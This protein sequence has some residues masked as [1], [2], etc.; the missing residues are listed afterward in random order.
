MKSSSLLS[1][2][3]LLAGFGVLLALLICVSLLGFTRTEHANRRLQ[4]AVHEQEVKTSLA[5]SIF[6]ITR[7]R[8]Q[9]ITQLLTDHDANARTRAADRFA[10]LGPE[11]ER[12]SRK[13]GEMPLTA[14]ERT[15]LSRVLAAA[16]RTRQVRDQI[17]L[18][19]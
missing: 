18:N 7:E 2:Y 1:R 16:E 11:L 19:V 12:A 9:L 15:A 13:L 4:Q 6:S 8:S 5:S 3:A 10:A 14:D 17:V